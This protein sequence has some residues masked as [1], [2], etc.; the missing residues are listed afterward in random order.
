MVITMVTERSGVSE[1]T[2]LFQSVRKEGFFISGWQR[3]I[4]QRSRSHFLKNHRRSSVS[5][6]GQGEQTHPPPLFAKT[7]HVTSKHL[8]MHNFLR[9]QAPETPKMA[10]PDP[11]P[12]KMKLTPLAWGGRCPKIIENS[13]KQAKMTPKTNMCLIS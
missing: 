9:G 2:C 12:F 4:A 5:S 3:H 1:V 10:L 8:K 6:G 13:D 11:P 7:Q